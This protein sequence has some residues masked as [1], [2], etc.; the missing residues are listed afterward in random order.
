M[1][2]GAWTVT[3]Q[4]TVVYNAPRVLDARAAASRDQRVCSHQN[5]NGDVELQHKADTRRAEVQIP[6]QQ[7]Q[8][9]FRDN[10]QT[11]QWIL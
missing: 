3:M 11:G 6:V 9:Q 2:D 5:V 7:E 4:Y 10:R 8:W 1:E